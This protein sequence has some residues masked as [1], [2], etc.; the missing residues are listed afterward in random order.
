[1]CVL[2]SL[3][4]IVQGRQ[5][6]ASLTAGLNIVPITEHFSMMSCESSRGNVSGYYRN[7]LGSLRAGTR[8]HVV[9][10]LAVRPAKRRLVSDSDVIVAYTAF[11]TAS[12][13][14]GICMR[15]AYFAKICHLD[16]REPIGIQERLEGKE[17]P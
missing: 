9:A 16:C 15:F 5:L 11:N 14:V 1:M 3:V 6:I 2:S 13:L 10:M 12:Q 17:F 7:Y 8:H 4:C